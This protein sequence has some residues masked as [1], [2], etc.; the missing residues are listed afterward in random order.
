MGHSLDSIDRRLLDDF[1]RDLPLIP[2]P[3]AVMGERLGISETDVISRLTRLKAGGTISRVGA[4]IRPNT[5]GASTLGAM[6]VPPEHIEEVAA[7]VSAEPGVNHSY[8]R[9]DAWNLWFVVTAPDDVALEGTLSR[10]TR[11]CGLQVLD[12]RLI[13]PFNIDLGF[14]LSGRS[15]PPLNKPLP[16]IDVMRNEDKPLLQALSDGLPLVARPYSA[17]ASAVGIEETVLLRRLRVLAEAGIIA[18]LGV[19]V[20]HRAIGWTENAMTVW[21]IPEHRIGEAGAR[22]AA[23]P[24]VTLCYQRRTVPGIWPYALYTMVHARSREEALSVLDRLKAMPHFAGIAHRILFS[25]RCFKQ[26]GALLHRRE[27]AA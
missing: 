17:L 9:E 14:S 5:A 21:D 19:I 3:F 20:R 13:R 24:G 2:R 16:S 23:C 4:T 8:L 15:M 25:T 27:A 6:K 22:A 11:R 12:L 26:T 10:I 18:R 1:Q 7:L